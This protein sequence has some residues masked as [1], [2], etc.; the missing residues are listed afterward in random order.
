[1]DELKTDDEQVEAI[2]KWWQENGRAIVLG[3]VIGVGGLAGYQYWKS[4]RISDAKAASNIY[5][6]VLAL[7]NQADKKEFI[8][9]ANTLLDK[10]ESTSYATLTRFALAKQYSEM[11]QWDDAARVLEKI[12][13]NDRHDGFTH[14]ARIRLIIV[15]LQSG[16]PD[17]ALSQIKR[18]DTSIFKSLYAELEGDI[19]MAMNELSLA[20]AAYKKALGSISNNE[21]RYEVVSMK[22][23]SIPDDVKKGS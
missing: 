20:R 6:E 23:N 11:A 2:K 8:T 19:Y 14:L 3:L 12:I 1:M 4:T 7:Q 10:Y 9:K 16:K 15:L 13:S 18:D 21:Q 22:L 17:Q 5:A